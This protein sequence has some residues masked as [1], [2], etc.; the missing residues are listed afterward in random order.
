MLLLTQMLLWGA[1]TAGMTC[2]SGLGMAKALVCLSILTMVLYAVKR[3]HMAPKIPFSTIRCVPASSSH[4]VTLPC[5]SD[6]VVT[7]HLSALG[8]G[9]MVWGV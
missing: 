2:V 9:Y 4:V 7:R 8:V 1:W 3:D 5:P 6:D